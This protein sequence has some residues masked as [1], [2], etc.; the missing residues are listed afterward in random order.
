MNR[1]LILK[2]TEHLNYLPVKSIFTAFVFEVF[3]RVYKNPEKTKIEEQL[4]KQIK[5][6]PYDIFDGY[7]AVKEIELTDLYI[8]KKKK[9][10]KTKIIILNKHFS[11]TNTL[12]SSIESFQMSSLRARIET[13]YYNACHH[14]RS[15]Y[16]INRVNPTTS[17]AI[18][19]HFIPQKSQPLTLTLYRLLS[20]EDETLVSSNDERI[21]F[22]H[23]NEYRFSSL[24]TIYRR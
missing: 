12:N 23:W 10:K 24:R 16:N 4:I 8:L 3:I 19:F 21:P 2:K 20:D 7:D 13:I 18:V 22:R 15:A 6:I 5:T 11:R 1:I 17:E 9:T 14:I